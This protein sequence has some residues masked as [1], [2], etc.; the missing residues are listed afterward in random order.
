MVTNPEDISEWVQD[1]L[2]VL[3]SDWD[4]RAI[5]LED[6]TVDVGG[7]RVDVNMRSV[8]VSEDI[9]TTVTR[10][11]RY[12]FIQMYPYAVTM[13]EADKTVAETVDLSV[14]LSIVGI[15]VVLVV[16]S[17]LMLP[18]VRLALDMEKVRL[19][20]LDELDLTQGSRLTEIASLLLGFQSMC[21]MLTEYKAFMPKTLF[22]SR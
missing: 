6:F 9:T 21:Q 13:E 10:T 7:E 17:F 16:I 2:D 15:T 11:V 19:L 20:D 5:P 12:L 14:I 22:D 1:V 3:G 4:T 18:L 8:Y